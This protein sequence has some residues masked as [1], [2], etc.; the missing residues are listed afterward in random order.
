MSNATIFI[1][2][3]AG[4]LECV[5]PYLWLLKRK[6]I[7]LKIIFLSQNAYKS[8]QRNKTIR[9]LVTNLC[10]NYTIL[11]VH[12]VIVCTGSST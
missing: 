3:S 5:I 6:G 8:F 7:D 2:S 12:L 10:I 4:E 11:S 1:R 9:D